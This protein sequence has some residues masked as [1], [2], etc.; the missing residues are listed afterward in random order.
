MICAAVFGTHVVCASARMWSLPGGLLPSQHRRQSIVFRGLSQQT[1]K[2][3]NKQTEPTISYESNKSNINQFKCTARSWKD[4]TRNCQRN[5]NRNPTWCGNFSQ[6]QIQNKPKSQ[7]EF[8]PRDTEEFKPNQNL[9]SN[10][11][12]E[13]LRNLSFSISTSWLKSP[14]HSGFR[15]AFRWQFRVSSSRERAVLDLSV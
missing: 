2:Q 1:N 8:V 11:C 5:A 6:M 7:F 10:Q 12:R 15:F 4:E 3:T 13:I 14:H 9:N